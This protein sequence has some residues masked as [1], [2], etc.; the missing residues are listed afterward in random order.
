M[1][2]FAR[3]GLG[4]RGC[5]VAQACA[6]PVCLLR[7]G[8]F[9]YQRDQGDA[10]L[11][12]S[13]CWRAEHGQVL[14][15]RSAHE[16]LRPGQTRCRSPASAVPRAFRSE[17]PKWVEHLVGSLGHPEFKTHEDSTADPPRARNS[18]LSEQSTRLD[19]NRHRRWVL[20]GVQMRPAAV[21]VLLFLVQF[22]TFQNPASMRVPRG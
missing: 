13:A 4:C 21:G 2:S 6:L 18:K 19:A 20:S 22:R 10:D 9:G 11:D 3:S 8:S 1:T 16:C 14:R 12:G 17:A 15:G 7:G 5:D